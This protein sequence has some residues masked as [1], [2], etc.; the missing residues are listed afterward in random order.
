M[1]NFRE[2]LRQ[3]NGMTLVEIMIVVLI[4]SFMAGGIYFV[5]SAGQASWFNSDIQIQMRQGLRR[6]LQRLSSELRQSKES[7]NA[8]DD[9]ADI[10][11][12][13]GV[14]TTDILTFSIPIICEAG[15]EFID[16]VT[17]IIENWGAP[18]NWGCTT[19]ICMD[20]DQDCLFLEYKYIK[21]YLNSDNELVR[22]ILDE[23]NVSKKTEV[24]A[25][26]ITDFQVTMSGNDANGYVYTVSISTQ[27]DSVTHRTMVAQASM[28]IYLRN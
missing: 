21:Y 6:S 17:E 23:N 22:E 20:Q 10:S 24:F 28:D 15:G 11:D 18:L 12:G 14:G 7:T 4:V 13:A 1:K 5:F 9:H 8:A 3:T 25:Q 19:L 26:D 16:P 27:K 2:K